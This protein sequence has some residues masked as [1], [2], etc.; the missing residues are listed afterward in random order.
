MATISKSETESPTT[1]SSPEDL[2]TETNL[3]KQ[4]DLQLENVSKI[5]NYYS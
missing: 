1:H 2:K 5:N 3:I 4:L